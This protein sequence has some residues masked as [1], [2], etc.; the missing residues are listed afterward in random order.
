MM[1]SFKVFQIK[2]GRLELFLE[3]SP[4]N[5]PSTDAT[6]GLARHFASYVPVHLIT[7]EAENGPISELWFGD[8]QDIA[9][10]AD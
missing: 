2:N 8:S 5:L 6:R 9:L 4:L 3:P 1:F 10:A 7:I